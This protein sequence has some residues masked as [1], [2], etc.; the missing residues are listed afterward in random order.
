M[1]AKRG[2]GTICI[3]CLEPFT[4]KGR[5]CPKCRDYWN[6]RLGQPLKVEDEMWV[7]GTVSDTI[8]LR[9]T[10]VINGKEP[11]LRGVY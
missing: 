6:E 3:D 8:R 4:G 1:L 11:Q 2:N 9:F 7:S 5:L 10:S